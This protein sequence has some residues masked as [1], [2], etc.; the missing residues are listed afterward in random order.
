MIIEELTSTLERLRD[1]VVQ[2]RFKTEVEEKRVKHLI[3]EMERTNKMLRGK[4]AK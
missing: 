3:D 2:E 4:N 1:Q